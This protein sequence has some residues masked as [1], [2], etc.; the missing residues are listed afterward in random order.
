M[1]LAHATLLEN[2]VLALLR[3]GHRSARTATWLAEV[4]GTSPRTIRAAIDRLVKD[5][6]NPIASSTEDTPGY[7][8]LQTEGERRRYAAQLVSRIQELRTRLHVIQSAPL[9]G[10][11]TPP[12]Q[13]T[14]LN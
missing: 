7:F 9:H 2:E 3:P 12:G 6:G 5:C 4:L 11:A 13:L 10:S 14:L 1:A 8:L